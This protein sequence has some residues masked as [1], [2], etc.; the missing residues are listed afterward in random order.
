MM[1]YVYRDG[2]LQELVNNSDGEAILN[3]K[4]SREAIDE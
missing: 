2:E 1:S 3:H 4:L